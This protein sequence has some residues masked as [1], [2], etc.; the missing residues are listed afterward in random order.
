MQYKNEIQ[1]LHIVKFIPPAFILILSLITLIVIYLEH[2]RSLKL[3][4]AQLESKEINI[5]QE[6]NDVVVNGYERELLQVM[7][8]L[9]NNAK[10]V[11]MDIKSKCYYRDKRQCWRC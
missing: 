4:W 9:L 5:I 10:D 8:N 1:I 11:L 6:L 3:V 7:I 2:Q